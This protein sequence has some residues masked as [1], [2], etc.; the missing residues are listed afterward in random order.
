MMNDVQ[1]KID[2]TK[3]N[4]QKIEK[5]VQKILSEISGGSSKREKAEKRR[6]DAEAKKAK[7][8]AK[9]DEHLEFFSGKKGLI[10]GHREKLDIMHMTLTE[11]KTKFKEYKKDLHQAFE[12][13]QYEVCVE[14]SSELSALKYELDEQ[15][16]AHE[17]N[18]AAHA[19]ESSLLETKQVSHA[20]ADVE[21]RHLHDLLREAES[22]HD[23]IAT[24]HRGALQELQQAES[25]YE[26][27]KASLALLEEQG[28]RAGLISI[29]SKMNK[30]MGKAHVAKQAVKKECNKF[31]N[32]FKLRDFKQIAMVG[33]KLIKHQDK[34]DKA[35]KHSGNMMLLL[36]DK[37]E[38]E[39]IERRNRGAMGAMGA[40][41]N[42]ATREFDRG[43]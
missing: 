12:N 13:K 20:Q 25:D 30:S 43:Y 2:T 15:T 37:S 18:M 10:D 5:V 3:A 19:N 38:L 42:D 29:M 14:L 22:H 11:L 9:V 23:E 16:G 1:E 28:A 32:C 35:E 6:K 34:Q 4:I 17:L 39:M 21:L 26:T 41:Q 8:K 33:K 24:A 40:N 27:Y 31:D 7:A 36:V